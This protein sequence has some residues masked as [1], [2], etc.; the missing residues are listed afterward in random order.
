MLVNFLASFSVLLGDLSSG[1]IAGIS[2]E[3][4]IRGLLT[5]ALSAAILCGSIW[6]ILVT[7]T[8]TRLGS[9]L[10]IAGFFGWCFCM[11]IFWWIYGIGWVGTS[12][13]WHVE[14]VFAD[15]PGS[16]P[17]GIGDA[18][19]GNVDELP[20][21][22]CFNERASFP[23]SGG[24]AA[25]SFDSS[26]AA[27]CTPKAVDV[28]MVYPGAE[29]EFV[30]QEILNPQVPEGKIP[31]IASELFGVSGNDNHEILEKLDAEQRSQ[32]FDQLVERKYQELTDA[33]VAS[34]DRLKGDPRHKDATA[35]QASIQ[36]SIDNQ[37]LKLNGLTLSNL[38]G[39]SADI[40]DW[41][42]EEEHLQLHGWNLQTAS[43][44]GEA[45]AVADAYLREGLFPNGNF[46]VLDAVQQGGKPPRVN[47]ALLTRVKFKF[48]DAM[49][50]KNPTNYTVV[51]VQQTLEK[52]SDPSKPP[53]IPEADP[54]KPIYSVVLIRDLGNL[55][56]IPALF[57]IF[58]LIMFLLSCMILHWRDLGLRQ[59]GLE[60]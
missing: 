45:A 5:V 38:R 42:I 40:A 46:I 34:N 41:A 26:S 30:L 16:Q 29:R 37:N 35:L 18:F 58:S 9:L 14:D 32:V 57:T 22:N 21:S 12:P 28:L 51:N 4:E 60:V 59:K 43:Q 31:A 20:D 52:P 49:R 50:I 1:M 3:P 55:R 7:N 24:V 25:F 39:Y 10:I 33:I 53:P 48:T 17:E 2:W 19:I 15:A 27:V 54:A 44:A 13:S 36:E 6:L 23:P 11:G 56:V 47:D 8:G